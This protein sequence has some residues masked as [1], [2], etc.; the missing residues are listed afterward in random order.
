MFDRRCVD[1][2]TG[3]LH[4]SFSLVVLIMDHRHN[5]HVLDY[6]FS[7]SFTLKPLRQFHFPW[8]KWQNLFK[9]WKLIQHFGQ[10]KVYI[11]VKYKHWRGDLGNMTSQSPQH[12]D[13]SLYLHPSVMSLKSDHR[14]D[15][16]DKTPIISSIYREPKRP[17]LSSMSV[18]PPSS[19]NK[20]ACSDPKY[21]FH[22]NHVLQLNKF[23]VP[24]NSLY[25]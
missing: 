22:R 2:Q 6:T 12:T 25:F 24:C 19:L 7:P 10:W 9:A 8:L 3:V 23:F 14:S 13:P 18:A 1:P 4:V 11:L 17:Q 20:N 21:S 15:D 16:F 5:V